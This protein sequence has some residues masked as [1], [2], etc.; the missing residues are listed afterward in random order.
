MPATK[1]EYV[2]PEV[3]EAGKKWTVVEDC[4]GGEITIREAREEYLPK[5]QM[6][7]LEGYN[8]DARYESYLTR[9]VF[10]NVVK[11]TLEALVGQLFLRQPKIVLGDRL[12]PLLQNAN[13]EGLGIEQLLRLCANNLLAYGRCGL[14]ADFPITD[15]E[16]TAASVDNGMLPTITF[17]EPWAITNWRVK[18]VNGKRKLTLLVL[19]EAVEFDDSAN[20]F[21]LQVENRY[22][23]YRLK[24]DAVTVEV[25]AEDEKLRESVKTITGGDGK[26]LKEIPFSF[27]GSK[28]NDAEIDDSPMYPIASINVAHWRNSAD[29]EESAYIVGQPTPVYTGLTQEWLDRNYPQGIPFGSRQSVSLEAGSDAKM[30]QALPNTLA[31]EAMKLKEEQMVSLGAKLINPQQQIERKEAEIQ[32]DAASQ[33]SVLMTVRNNIQDAMLNTLR[34]AG[35]FLN[36]D[37]E[38]EVEMNDNFDLTTL[39]SEEHR[40]IRETYE[41]GHID[42]GSLH[43]ALRR[44]GFVKDTEDE[45]RKKI[46]SDVAFRQKTQLQTQSE[47]TN[48]SGQPDSSNTNEN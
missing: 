23:I 14:L 25:W 19:A 20:E 3:T 9:A 13:E 28:N 1:E 21:E 39:S 10:Y 36:T 40:Q 48:V 24:D 35:A 43:S 27:L 45:T 18:H 34:A 12:K 22:R 42:Y 44:S 2:R 16:V 8:A 37:T 5:P 7:D 41:G 4:L 6:I 38:P 33:R 46:L 47:N 31:Y 30:L 11:P 32:I 29:Y 15:G 26:P 17:Y